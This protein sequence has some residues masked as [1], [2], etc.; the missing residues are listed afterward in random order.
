[1]VENVIPLL[2]CYA[3]VEMF[4]KGNSY[5]VLYFSSDTGKAV[6]ILCFCVA[7][8]YSDAFVSEFICIGK[9][10]TCEI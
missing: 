4:M 8:V 3:S 1:M 7:P 9:Y 6:T 2:L 10:N 5:S